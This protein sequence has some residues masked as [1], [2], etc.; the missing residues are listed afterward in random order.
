MTVIEQGF[1]SG[2]VSD[3]KYKT[4]P[5]PTQPLRESLDSGGRTSCNVVTRGP[6]LLE[7]IKGTSTQQG[8]ACTM[9]ALAHK[10]ICPAEYLSSPDIALSL[11]L[12]TD[13]HPATY[14]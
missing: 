5:Y 13:T 3:P 4:A 10:C 1:C 9:L 14:F 11:A 8:P 2:L 12:L 6:Y 7:L